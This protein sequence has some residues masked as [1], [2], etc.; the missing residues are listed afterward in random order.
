MFCG[1]A[2]FFLQSAGINGFGPPQAEF[3]GSVFLSVLLA[4]GEKQFGV[5]FLFQK[6]A[7]IIH[8]SRI[9]KKLPVIHIFRIKKLPV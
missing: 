4:A 1:R 7:S 3:F 8:I 5:F 2:I 9:P 6:A